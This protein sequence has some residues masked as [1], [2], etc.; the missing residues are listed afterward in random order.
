MRHRWRRS[1]ATSSNSTGVRGDKLD[2]KGILR[3]LGER[4]SDL[5]FPFETIAREFRLI[6]TPMVPVIVPY[7]GANGDDRRAERLLNELNWVERPSRV[8]RKLQPYTVQIPPL[9]RSALLSAG[10]VTVVREEQFGQQ[11]IVLTNRDLYRTDV[12]LT[13]DDP[14]FHKAENLGF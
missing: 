13:W 12:G 4:R 6:E 1:R 3:S 7:G 2:A 8:A 14:S 9:A 10:S 11:F 5:N